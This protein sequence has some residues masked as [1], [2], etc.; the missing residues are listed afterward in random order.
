[1][2]MTTSDSREQGRQP[3]GLA[4]AAV[5]A[6]LAVALA[7]A[8][9]IPRGNSYWN[10]SDGVYLY[11]ANAVLHGHQLYTDFASAQPPPLYYVGAAILALG[12]SAASFRTILALFNVMTGITVLIAVYRL[13]RRPYLAAVAGALALITPRAL[14]DAA[15][16]LPE[17]FAAPLIMAAAL[18]ASRRT[19]AALGGVVGAAAIA[20]KLA[21]VF[22]AGALVFGAAAARRYVT[23]LVA[24]GLAF[25]AVFLAV[26][27]TD[28]VDEV[29]TAQRQVGF[30]SASFIWLEVRQAAWNLLPFVPAVAAAWIWRRRAQDPALMRAMLATAV[31]SL[32]VF[33]TIVKYGAYINLAVIAEP[34][35]LT[36]GAAGAAWTW[37]MRGTLRGAARVGV[38]AGLVLIA[39]GF[40]QAGGL[41][42]SPSAPWP[43]ARPGSPSTLGWHDSPAQTD[44][45]L[46]RIR[47]CPPDLAYSGPPY[48]A[49]LAQRRMPGGQGD[50]FITVNAP[51]NAEFRAAARRDRPRCPR[52]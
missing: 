41:L 31:G 29:V 26:F 9:L 2:A 6:V 40:A 14:H 45:E 42:L 43:F 16:L 38:A 10:F 23:G 19:T 27:G 28:L 7:C 37:E 24:A 50:P 8:I 32:A 34:P 15:N 39:L 12:D 20:F 52:R 46:A 18:L 5:F 33:V 3:F 36:L 1:M 47:G 22:P 11:S 35:L 49:F 44:A 17:T 48:F 25:T 13:T 51:T 21:F 30:A 4:P